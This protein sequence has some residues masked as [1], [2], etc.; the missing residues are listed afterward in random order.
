MLRLLEHYTSVQG[1]GPRVGVPTQFIRF[2]G[3]NLKCP[4]WPCDTP[5]AIDPKLYRNEQTE[6]TPNDIRMKAEQF[7]ENEGI[8]N[9]CLTGGEPMLQNR[10]AMDVLVQ[11][12]R[13]A[14]F[15]LEMFS[16][17]T[18]PYTPAVAEN[19]SIVLDWK[20]PGSGEDPANPERIKNAD[21]LYNYTS[22]REHTVKFTIANENDL[23]AALAVYDKH[24]RTKWLCDIYV[25]PV[26]HQMDPRRIV[27]FIK[28]EKL[29]WKLNLQTH[30]F[31][32]GDVRSV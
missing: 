2:A 5:E 21:F 10:T 20:L 19:V 14:G 24:L 28:A 17:G 32:Y 26:W 16:N 23:E 1:E 31:I 12:L 30:K 6:V 29:D 13:K 18:L 3:C 11:L 15:E 7:W 27:E 25:G 4:L 8:S 22:V 9:L